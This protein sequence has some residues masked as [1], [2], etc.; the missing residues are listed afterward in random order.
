MPRYKRKVEVED[1]NR[2][3]WVIGQVLAGICADLFDDE[4]PIG[5]MIKGLLKEIA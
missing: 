1:L 3:F 4:G 5:G 2:N